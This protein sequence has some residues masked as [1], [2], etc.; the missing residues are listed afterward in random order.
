M[1]CMKYF[2]SSPKSMQQKTSEIASSE[3]QVTVW[4]RCVRVCVCVQGLAA[5]LHSSCHLA[6]SQVVVVV[7][8]LMQTSLP[9]SRTD[10]RCKMHFK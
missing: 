8:Q 2:V 6:T 9:A 1:I 7:A 4:Q 5:C 10:S 3:R